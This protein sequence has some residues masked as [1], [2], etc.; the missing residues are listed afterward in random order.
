MKAMS[1]PLKSLLGLAV[2]AMT[3]LAAPNVAFGQEADVERG[4]SL[5][6]TCQT[7]HGAQGQGNAAMNAPRLAGQFPWYLER[8]L[9]H[10]RNGIRGGEKDTYGALMAPMAA[11][12]PDDQAVTDVTAYIATF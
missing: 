7:C 10:F 3:A 12:L 4:R 2:A 11:A 9:R 8:Q 6:R 1:L 5:Y